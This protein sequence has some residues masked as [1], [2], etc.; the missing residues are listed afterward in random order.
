MG[1]PVYQPIK[2]A[3]VSTLIVDQI[4]DHIV[5]GNLSPGDPL[6]SE[7]ELMKSFN[8][9]RS[10]LREAL[11][12]LDAMGFVT[13]E[14][15]KR[16]R[17]KSLVPESFIDPI[18][19]L[20]KEDMTTV[21]E[22]IEVRKCMETWNAQHAAERANDS[23]IKRLKEN[24]QSMKL[25]IKKKQSLIEDDAAFHLLISEMTHN[26]IQTHLMTS[27]YGII[28]NSVGICY[29]ENDAS[30]IL[31]EHQRIYL[32]IKQRD[33]NLARNEMERHLDSVQARIH[34]FFEK[35]VNSN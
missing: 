33:A 8:V 24:I 29:E 30:S 14:Q 17:V 15:R 26:T 1:M 3:K 18:H 7:R 2:Q 9:S 10:S 22:V 4:K 11:K 25:K 5:H 35:K 12:I 23:D 6:P 16:T 32:A 21:L 19:T 13:I 20:L 31:D 28:Q 34:K 27:I